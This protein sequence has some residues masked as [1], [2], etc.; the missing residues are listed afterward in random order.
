MTNPNESIV[1]TVTDKITPQHRERGAYVYIRQSSLKQVLHNQESLRNQ[2][3]LAERAV[4]LGWIP[5]RI[6]VIAADLGQSGQERNRP[7]FQELVA[8]VSLGHVG[9]ILAY[10]ASRLARSNADW[11]TLLDLAALGE[12][13]IADTEGGYDPHS[14]NDRLLLGLRGM[15]SEAELHL[16]HLRLDAGRLRQVRDGTFRQNLPTGLVRGEDGRVEKD[17]DLQV[18][19]AI[20]LVFEHFATFGSVH[21][22]LHRLHRAKILLPR[23]QVG[24]LRHG[25][26]QW[27][28]PTTG[29]LLAILHNPAY[30]GAFVRATA[31][32]GRRGA[33]PAGR[34][35]TGGGVDRAAAGGLSCL[36]LL[37]GVRGQSSPPGQ[38][39]LPL[40][41]AHKAPRV[42]GRRSSSDWRPAAAAGA[43]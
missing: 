1:A 39:S 22:V 43:R 28:L 6:H 36:H 32:P 25:D 17:S 20:E 7:G 9:L 4:A 23:R 37:G 35:A 18:Q 16:L 12:A 34:A 38:Q 14:Y 2:Y 33:R 21:Q 15:L 41:L 30:A 19:H 31:A 5:E 27:R 13:L 26:L 40:S 42:V 8:E 11:Y 29:A 3:A 24:G 10:E